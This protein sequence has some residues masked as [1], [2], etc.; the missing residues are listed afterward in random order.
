MCLSEGQTQGHA[1][2][3]RPSLSPG[4]A[5]LNRRVCFYWRLPHRL[6]EVRAGQCGRHRK[7]QLWWADPGVPGRGPSRHSASPSAHGC[8]KAMAS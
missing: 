1:P 5:P 4:T 7:T 8:C 6:P 3:P 2:Q